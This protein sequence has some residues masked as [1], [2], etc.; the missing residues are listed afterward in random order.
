MNNKLAGLIESISKDIVTITPPPVIAYV[1]KVATG[2]IISG[3]V[4]KTAVFISNEELKNEEDVIA[5]C[6]ANLNI[7]MP[8]NMITSSSSLNFAITEPLGK[9]ASIGKTSR[10]KTWEVVSIQGV[11]YLVKCINTDDLDEIKKIASVKL[12]VCSDTF[13]VLIHTK[14]LREASNILNALS[15]MHSDNIYH[16]TSD[17]YIVFDHKANNPT[18]CIDS[19]R[20]SLSENNVIIEPEDVKC[21]KKDDVEPEDKIEYDIIKH[22]SGFIHN[23]FSKIASLNQVKIVLKYNIY[24]D[25]EYDKF[26]ERK[27]KFMV[28]NSAKMST[29]EDYPIIVTG[30]DIL[31]KGKAV[32][33][34]STDLEN[35]EDIKKELPKLFNSNVVDLNEM[36]ISVD[37]LPL[38]AEIPEEKPKEEVNK[39][40]EKGDIN[41]AEDLINGPLKE[42]VTKKKDDQSVSKKFEFSDTNV[43]EAFKYTAEYFKMK[44]EKISDTE[45]VITGKEKD[46]A[47]LIQT[48]T[49]KVANYLNRKF[50]TKIKFE[51]IPVDKLIKVYDN[52]AKK[53]NKVEADK[54]STVALGTSE[55]EE[56]PTYSESIYAKSASVINTELPEGYEFSEDYDGE[57][58]WGEAD[59]HMNVFFIIVF[60]DTGKAM[61]DRYYCSDNIGHLCD[62]ANRR[63][64]GRNFKFLSTKHKKYVINKES[65]ASVYVDQN[66][67]KIKTEKDLGVDT[68]SPQKPKKVVDNDGVEYTKND[69][70]Q[71]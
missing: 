60:D 61:N 38:E 12:K 14:T 64:K 28:G 27:F 52:Y 57:E 34:V 49:E 50:K 68:N 24:D 67:E 45:Y 21:I 71:E 36:L 6:K 15:R 1:D 2:I 53:D 70:V 17:D 35:V 9:T 25:V 63:Y 48:V 3:G 5:K 37:V 51:D 7:D 39:S 16:N 47:N 55:S 42:E 66:G 32:I 41:E 20:K 44:I 40:V 62:Y 4:V 69:I 29:D 33:Y 43:A 59:K 13:S 19:V 26:I 31:G 65:N 23:V 22:E 18:E 30:Y 58:F 11:D 10:S 8:L 56:N 46:F 54:K